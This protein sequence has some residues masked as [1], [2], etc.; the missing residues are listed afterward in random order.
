MYTLNELNHFD[1]FPQFEKLG[2]KYSDDDLLKDFCNRQ[3]E[4]KEYFRKF[5]PNS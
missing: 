2:I 1:N 5:E 3:T 4:A